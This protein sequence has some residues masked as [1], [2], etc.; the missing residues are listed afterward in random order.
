[1]SWIRIDL[2]EDRTEF[3]PGETLAGTV[4]WSLDEQPEAVS[5]RLF[6]Y[7]CGKGDRDVEIVREV[8]FDV[9]GPEQRERFEVRLPDGPHSFSG[10][11]ISLIWAIETVA[12][13]GPDA[14]R[15][16]LVVS[17]TG[18][19]LLLQRAAGEAS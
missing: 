12:E 16:E 17:P 13:P 14:D 2:D 1:M 9:R 7:T 19:E 6:W 4:H 5:L 8:P 3:L 18:R 15:V 10:R 11:L